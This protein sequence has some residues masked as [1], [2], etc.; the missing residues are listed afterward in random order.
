M[1]SR[2]AVRASGTNSRGIGAFGASGATP[3]DASTHSPRALK[4]ASSQRGSRFGG[5]GVAFGSAGSPPG[6]AD[7]RR[8]KSMGVALTRK[9]STSNPAGQ[10]T[11][12]QPSPSA[13]T[14][15]PRPASIRLLPVGPLAGNSTAVL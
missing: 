5:G 13:G 1:I 8:G 12:N 10:F 4:I 6:L 9:Y 2:E 11:S 3:A 7:G 14:R 15:Y